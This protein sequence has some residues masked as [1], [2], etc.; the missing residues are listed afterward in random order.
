MINKSRV[1][2]SEEGDPARVISAGMQ[3]WRKGVDW[4]IRYP[5]FWSFIAF[6]VGFARHYLPYLD[7]LD[8]FI[9]GDMTDGF[10][11]LWVMEHARSFLGTG[12]LQEYLN[13]RFFVPDNNLVLFWSDMLVFPGLIFTFLSVLTQSAVVAFNVSTVVL[14]LIGFLISVDFFATIYKQ[15]AN[16]PQ[17]KPLPVGTAVGVALLA[18]VMNFSD[19]RL[20]FTA[21][22]QN[23]MS[24]FVLLG[25]SFAIRY[26][27]SPSAFRLGAML[28]CFLLLL[29]S[30]PYYALFFGLLLAFYSLFY[31]RAFGIGVI[32][33][34]LKSQG[35]IAA[36]ALIL[37]LPAVLGYLSVQTSYT[38]QGACSSEWRHIFLPDAS[39]K[40]AKH[41]RP[42]G[43]DMSFRGHES[44]A[45]SGLFMAPVVLGLLLAKTWQLLTRS[46][47][48]K[49]MIL[50]CIVVATFIGQRFVKQGCPKIAFF[51]IASLLAVM[52]IAAIVNLN[53][54]RLTPTWLFVAMFAGYGTAMGP[55]LEPVNA[56]DPS[57]WGVLAQWVPAY[58]SIRAV[59]RFG[60]LGYSFALALAWYVVN[61]GSI[62]LGMNR[63]FF[64]PKAILLGAA[65][66]S[67][68]VD[69]PRA[70]YCSRL[71]FSKLSPT[72]A[73]RQV[74]DATP[75]R[76][77]ILPVNNLSLI[78]GHMLYF[79]R[80][81]NV[82]LV[83]GYSGKLS[84]LVLT[85]NASREKMN[86]ALIVHVISRSKAT[87]L[88][89]DKRAF[90]PEECVEIGRTF[91]GLVRID[92]RSFQLLELPPSSKYTSTAM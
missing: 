14:I 8:H 79:E 20:M 73:E 46:I 83:N 9:F 25:T 85:L 61:H 64:L 88:L 27:R 47:H 13:T 90:S 5:W 67:A 37:C 10:F 82:E 69:I 41:L 50:S 15:A 43:F 21:H 11:N 91:S 87:H 16:W 45:Y 54:S 60:A 22:F 84:D 6:L 36:A 30:A 24:Y 38:C 31:I 1:T 71:D 80:L 66:L 63:R 77:L 18:Y 58:N 39:M 52:L 86:K 59:G 19:S 89:L 23:Y 7:N 42:L 92:N 51:M 70:P 81:A 56:F 74:F 49:L 72:A 78:P 40:I 3:R 76:I 34:R 32:V 26:S 75:C 33:P 53:I 35:W 62:A 28:G 29:Y 44:L 55:S 68:V 4:L 2:L 17:N 65:A 12:N 57:F 48:A